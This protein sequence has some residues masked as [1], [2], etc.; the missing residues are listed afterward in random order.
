M[1]QNPIEPEVPAYHIEL[2][3]R[4]ES[5]ALLKVGFVGSALGDTVLRS[6]VKAIE[7]VDLSGGGV[8]LINGPMTLP[9]A[10]VIAHKVLH[11]FTAVAVYDP[12]MNG[13]LVVASHGSK[14][15]PGDLVQT[16][17]FGI[18]AS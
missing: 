9:V 6:A 17:D 13:Y 7:A 4:N 11:L 14:H 8:V 16:S 12:K 5:A 18:D 15:N 2:V 1:N 3:E 10:F